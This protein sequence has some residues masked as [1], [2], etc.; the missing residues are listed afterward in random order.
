MHALLVRAKCQMS[1]IFIGTSVLLISFILQTG[2][3]FK[4]LMVKLAR[5]FS[6]FAG[7]DQAIHNEARALFCA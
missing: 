7:I 2:V 4:I 3:F 5:H 1:R 6:P